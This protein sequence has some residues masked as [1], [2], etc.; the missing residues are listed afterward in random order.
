MPIIIFLFFLLHIFILTGNP[1]TDL[2]QS[3]LTRANIEKSSSQYS[4]SPVF[5]ARRELSLTFA[6]YSK[7]TVFLSLLALLLFIIKLFKKQNLYPSHFLLPLLFWAIAYPLVFTDAAYNHDYFLIY[8]APFFALAPVALIYAI[9]QKIKNQKTRLMVKV[10]A[11]SL[12]LIQFLQVLP[13][14]SVLLKSNASQD[15][16]ILGTFLKGN[17]QPD[18][19]ILVLSGQFGAH[20]GAFTNYYADKSITYRD[21]SLAEFEEKNIANQYNYIVFV[22]DRDTPAQVKDLLKKRYLWKSIDKF[23]VF[24][25]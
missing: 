19:K 23:T 22:E 10:I 25:K 17:T 11:I 1:F 2:A 13:F 16:Y 15:G 12:P 3:F 4:L 24:E 20:L 5:F 7:L 18:K 8:L 6:Y 21:F 9:L 14:L